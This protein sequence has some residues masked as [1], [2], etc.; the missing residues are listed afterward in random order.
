MARRGKLSKKFAAER[1][2][3]HGRIDKGKQLEY[4]IFQNHERTRSFTNVRYTLAY[5]KERAKTLKAGMVN[6]EYY[7]PVDV[8][9]QEQ[10]PKTKNLSTRYIDE[11]GKKHFIP[12]PRRI[13][14]D[15]RATEK[16]LETSAHEF[17]VSGQR[18]QGFTTWNFRVLEGKGKPGEL[19]LY[20]SAERYIFI[21]MALPHV[22]Y[23]NY[24]T[25]FDAYQCVEKK[26]NVFWAGKRKVVFD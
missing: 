3:T 20:F 26:R 21:M 17:W 25:K 9:E 6:T 10:I 4:E 24:Y 14:L 8:S 7:K 19:R 13:T 11:T 2:K 23:S 18:G 16:E 5:R 12:S 15:K 1:I 22:W